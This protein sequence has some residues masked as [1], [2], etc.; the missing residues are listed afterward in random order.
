M[1]KSCAWCGSYAV[2]CCRVGSHTAPAAPKRQEYVGE[3]LWDFKI[4]QII[5]DNKF[6]RG[7][8]QIALDKELVFPDMMIRALKKIPNIRIIRE[9]V[10]GFFFLKLRLRQLSQEICSLTQ[11]PQ[12]QTYVPDQ[13]GGA[14][15]SPAAPHRQSTNDLKGGGTE[16]LDSS[17]RFGLECIWLGVRLNKG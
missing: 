7:V 10:D 3:G 14:L 2:N 13:G 9:Q 5:P 15:Q 1:R 16:A 12:R 11:I 8:G 4:S 6:M 17:Q